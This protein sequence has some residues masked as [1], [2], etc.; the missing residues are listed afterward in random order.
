MKRIVGSVDCQRRNG[1]KSKKYQEPHKCRANEYKENARNLVLYKLN[2][3]IEAMKNFNAN[4]VKQPGINILCVQQ[5]K[6]YPQW[7]G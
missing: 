4:P 3:K 1:A 2:K 7:W 6:I 5:N